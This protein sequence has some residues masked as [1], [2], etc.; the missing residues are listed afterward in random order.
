MALTRSQMVTALRLDL[1]DS[2]SVWSAT[3]LNR[4]ITKAVH[5]L[6]RFIPKEKV[7]ETRLDFDEV[8]AE[9]V[10]LVAGTKALAN[11][12]VKWESEAVLDTDS[13]TCIRGTDYEIDYFNG[14]ITRIA[15]GEIASATETIT[16]TYTIHK[17]SIDISSLTDIIRVSRVEYPVGDV[18]QKY[19]NVDQW[20]DILTIV[21]HPFGSQ[22][23]AQKDLSN[24][25]HILIQ[26][27]A[28]HTD[29]TDSV[30]GSYDEFHDE[31]V[32]KGAEAY[33]WLIEAA[34]YEHQAAA[35]F[36]SARAALVSATGAQS[37]L[38]TALGAIT[39]Q[40]GLSTTTLAL[41]ASPTD[42]HAAIKTALDAANV[43]L[44]LIVVA[45]AGSGLYDA[46]QIDDM[47]AGS[48]G[49]TYLTNAS[50]PSM[51]SYLV[52][53]DNLITPVNTGEDVPS[54]Y[55]RY[56][57][58]IGA[59]HDRLRAIV[60]LHIQRATVHTTAALGFVQEALGRARQIE[61][62]VAEANVEVAG[63]S[64]LAREVEGRVGQIQ[65]YVTI[66]DRYVQT[67]HGNQELADRYR[68]MGL[69]KRQEFLTIL[70]SRSQRGMDRHT[71]STSAKK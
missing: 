41:I 30:A 62:L 57:E 42:H 19:V 33:A 27:E 48:E 1:K 13:N 45:S 37:G 53:G 11:K 32:I 54:T 20:G 47:A 44:D 67:G 55:A 4:C 15:D 43:E 6:S 16:V 34:K 21:N 36:D 59:L 51:K 8:S 68:D 58:G 12:P 39:T 64:I 18:P 26:Y 2:G 49:N 56:A 23:D 38:S 7:Y 29:P 65:S 35:N 50:E 25:R 22:G 71:S 63:A 66:A 14:T 31:I 9:S 3:E 61:N 69:I 70:G 60:A 5:D 40:V 10:T 46:K 17:F 52:T 28:H 24:D